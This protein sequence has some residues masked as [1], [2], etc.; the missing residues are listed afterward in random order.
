MSFSY[1]TALTSVRD[2][3]RFLIRDTVQASAVFTDEELDGVLTLK[4]GD[5]YSARV[6]LLLV[7]LADGSRF[8]KWTQAQNSV[9]KSG[10]LDALKALLVEAKAQAT[11]S[12]G[13]GA[14]IVDF[15]S[16]EIDYYGVRVDPDNSI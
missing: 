11:A 9:D 16:N 8:L 5:V 4:G 1:N 2:Q 14:G 3:L 6:E 13:D 15:A 7:M 12:T 10:A